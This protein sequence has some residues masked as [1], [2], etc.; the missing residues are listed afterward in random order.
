MCRHAL[1]IALS[2]LLVCSF[3]PA[4]FAG[5]TKELEKQKAKEAEFKRKVVEWGTNKQ[6]SVKLHSGEKIEGR[7]A[8]INDDA[9]TVQ[10][11]NN[12]TIT[13]K[14]IRFSEIKKLS[15]KGNASKAVGYTA[16]GVL[17]GVG[18]V[19]AILFA[20]YAANEN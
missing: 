5:Q 7:I 18:A 8:A 6:V 20:V 17:A 15:Q 10:G 9:F 11:L 12:S 1:S 2:L 19:V 14:D 3:A 16:L 4:T 13:S